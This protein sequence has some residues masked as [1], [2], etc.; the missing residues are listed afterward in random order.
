MGTAEERQALATLPIH[1]GG[2]SRAAARRTG[3]RGDGYFAGGALLPDER[4]SQWE[5]A[6][7]TVHGAFG[8]FIN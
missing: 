4:M 3:L 5:L 1:I 8:L 7:T 2:S 6:R